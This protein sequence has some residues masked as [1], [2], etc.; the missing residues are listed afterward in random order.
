MLYSR[1]Y[2]AFNFFGEINLLRLTSFLK[3]SNNCYKKPMQRTAPVFFKMF[4]IIYQL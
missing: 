3:R 4:P 1:V 2:H